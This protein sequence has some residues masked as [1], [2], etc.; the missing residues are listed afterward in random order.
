M[1]HILDRVPKISSNDCCSL[2]FYVIDSAVVSE[3]K[4]GKVQYSSIT[5]VKYQI[6]NE[7]RRIIYAMILLFWEDE[8]KSVS[9]CK[10]TFGSLCFPRKRLQLAIL[11]PGNQ[12]CI[13]NIDLY[14][15][16]C[17]LVF[18]PSWIPLASI[19][20]HLAYEV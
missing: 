17:L 2:R 15:I 5:F 3:V 7:P 8:I 1:A 4:S 14:S 16:V 6:D 9:D 12:H 20:A 10:K 19:H 11:N 18:L 13:M